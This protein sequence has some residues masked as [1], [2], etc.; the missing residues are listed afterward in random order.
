MTHFGQDP[1]RPVKKGPLGGRFFRILAKKGIASSKSDPLFEHPKF[2]TFKMANL[3][4]NL[5]KLDVLSIPP[6]PEI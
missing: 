4:Q 2:R 5:S 6:G 3:V 1:N